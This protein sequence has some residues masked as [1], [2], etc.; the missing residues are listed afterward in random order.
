MKRRI[1]FYDAAGDVI[2]GDHAGTDA[3]SQIPKTDNDNE[4]ADNRSD[5]GKDPDE[6]SSRQA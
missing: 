1:Y 3:G 6:A 4:K 5:Q 2:A